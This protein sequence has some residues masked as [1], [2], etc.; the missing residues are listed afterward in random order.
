[1]Q[2]KFDL[3]VVGGGA[4]GFYAA[5][6]TAMANPILKICILEQSGQLLSKVRISGG[7]RCN[8]TTSI[9]EPAELISNYPRGKKELLGPF[10][11]HGPE[12]V[13]QFFESH[14]I[15]LKTEADGRVFPASNSSSSI[16][17]CLVD[18]AIKHEIVVM[19]NTALKN[20]GKE[21]D[22]WKVDSKTQSFL[23]PKV[24][25]A[26]GSNI[27]IWKMLDKLQIPIVK[28]VPSL[29]TFNIEDARIKDLSGIS[30]EAEVNILDCSRSK[31]QQ[32]KTRG[33]VLIT[34]W[35]LSGPAILKAS[36][37]GARIIEEKKYQFEISINWL[38]Q[39]SLAQIEKLLENFKSEQGSKKIRMS[40]PFSMSKRLWDA[41]CESSGISREEQWAQLK[42]NNRINLIDSL[43]QC[44][45]KVSGKSTF[46]EEFVSAGGV[47]LN[48]INFKTMESKIH[49][50]IY[51]AG[52]VIDVD[53]ITG[54][55]NFQNAWTT[56]YIAAMDVAFSQF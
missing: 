33:S 54:G 18:L 51:F 49:S 48:S 37:F 40:N 21:G 11:V 36:A 45:F 15:P 4:A 7:G 3:I 42:S 1:M 22:L 39:N 50:G 9:C 28:P 30:S 5:I 8:L 32:I 19:T 55:F 12:Q 25:I 2:D 53:A 6:H 16:V 35:G 17:N 43:R 23:S 56:A 34:H 13:F 44:L 26:T 38:P 41:L 14:G 47:Q 20:I 24:L 31:N 29:F 10:Y 27:S 46:K 52:E